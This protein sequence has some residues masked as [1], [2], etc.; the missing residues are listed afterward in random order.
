MRSRRTAVTFAKSRRL[1]PP[2]AKRTEPSCRTHSLREP[3]RGGRKEISSESYNPRPRV[4]HHNIV[5]EPH[6]SR[7]ALAAVL[8]ELL[9]VEAPH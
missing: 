4:Y 7:H 9:L 6:N 5:D 8:A 3:L 2:I 1:S